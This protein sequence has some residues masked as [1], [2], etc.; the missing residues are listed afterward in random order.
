MWIGL[1]LL[2]F[3][4]GTILGSFAKAVADRLKKQNSLRG[5]SYC[6]NCKHNLAWYDLFPVISYLMLRG[7]CR[8]CH[9]QIPFS[10]FASEIVMGGLVLILFLTQ[11]FDLN[12][13]LNPTFASIPIILTF[14]FKIIIVL[15]LFILFLTDL[16]TGLLP[17]KITFPAVG[18][19]LVYWLIICSLN[20]WLLYIGLK[21]NVIGKYLMPPYSNY[22]YTLIYR[23]WEPAIYSIILGIAAS[24][25]FVFLIIITKGKGMGWGDVKFVLFIGI[26]LGFPNGLIALFLAFL[27]GALFSIILLIFGKKRFG[28]TIPFGPFISFGAYVALL[29]GPQISNWYLNSFKMGY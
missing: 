16:K 29:W 9:K 13:F 10:N 5:R 2:G 19:G 26:V 27:S 7:K 1:S 11:A 21:G 23:V 18:I 17:D 8:Y 24:L 25:F 28:Q 4:I 12:I 3:L 14:I 20:S 15:I 6:A 22:L